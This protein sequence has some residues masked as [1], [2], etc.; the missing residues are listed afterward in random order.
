M[1]KRTTSIYITGFVTGLLTVVLSA[2]TALASNWDI[3]SAHSAAEFSVR[4]LTVSNVRGQFSKV[5][6]TLNLN[7]QDITKSSV[8][9]TID[10]TTIDTREP[11]RDAHLKSPDFFDTAKFSTI[12][13][14]S[15]K[16]EKVGDK[17]K[18]TGDLT[19]HG[20]TRPVVLDVDWS[21]SEIHDPFGNTKRGATATTKINRK[22]FGLTWNKAMEAGGVVVGEEVQI[23]IDLEL[24]KKK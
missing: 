4:H 7:D 3:D 1:N 8:N 14:Q 2:G 13:F 18:V 10:V 12:T 15:K 5:S 24:A 6:G 21:A 19:L 16:V 9:A 20:V 17:L 22:D 23:T 11:K